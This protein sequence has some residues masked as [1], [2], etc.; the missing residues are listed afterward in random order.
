MQIRSLTINDYDQII[1]LWSRAGLP[2]KPKGRDSKQAIKAQMRLNPEF[3]LGAFDDSRLVGVV[4]ASFDGRKGWLNRLAVDSIY[5]RR[6]IG[7]ALIA[8]AEK[9]LGR[10]GVQVFAALIYDSNVASKSLFGKS[11]YVEYRDVVYFSKR[12]SDDV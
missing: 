3:F 9:I 4:V 1:R 10:H 5:Q 7:K 11:G 12:S 2:F 8:E 6:G